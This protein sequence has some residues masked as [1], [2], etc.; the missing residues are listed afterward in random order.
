VNRDDLKGTLEGILLSM[1]LSIPKM[2]DSWSDRMT[3]YGRSLKREMSLV[4]LVC[5]D[6]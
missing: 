6:V 1:A 2:I 5:Q 3:V 4:P